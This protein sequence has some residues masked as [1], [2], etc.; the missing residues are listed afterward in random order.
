MAEKNN[1]E[2]KPREGKT[3]HSAPTGILET[4]DPFEVIG[5]LVFIIV[6]GGYLIGK[7]V[8]FWQS[9]EPFWTAVYNYYIH[10]LSYL[11]P[12]SILV[13]GLFLIG[14][15]YSV[16]QLT[17][18]NK[19]LKLKF[20]SSKGHGHGG[21]GHGGHD[22]HETSSGGHKHTALENEMEKKWA[23]V[24]S[25]LESNNMSDWKMAIFEADIML[26]DMVDKMGYKGEGLG[27]KLEKIEKSDFDNLD[28]AWEV[29]KIRNAV[30]HEGSEFLLT[31]EETHRIIGL[32]EKI[33][34]EFRY[35]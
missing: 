17:R 27:E 21:H 4:T 12:I 15:V 30:A 10:L 9:D 34:K 3:E 18:L 14:L 22:E 35:I 5:I 20:H 19:Q 28:N 26:E 16:R 23:K 2:R 33:F 8:N 7:F 25:Y 29:H 32:Y 31:K 6:V 1:H 11:L 24:L 13:S